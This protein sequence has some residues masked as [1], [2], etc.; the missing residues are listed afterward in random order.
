VEMKLKKVTDTAFFFGSDGPDEEVLAKC[1]DVA[2]R[3][4]HYGKTCIHISALKTFFRRV[5]ISFR[6]CDS[7]FLLR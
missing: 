4:G 2:E 3:A 5:Y 6:S 7:E 1:H